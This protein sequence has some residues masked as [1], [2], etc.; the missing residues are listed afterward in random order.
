MRNHPF[1][2]RFSS[3]LDNSENLRRIVKRLP[4]HLGTKLADIAYFISEPV[5]GTDPGREPHFS[6]LAKFVDEKSRVASSMYGVDLTK[7]TIQSKHE[8]ASPS[9]NQNNTVKITTLATN[10]E[11]GVKHER[12]CSCCSGTCIALA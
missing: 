7:K 3:D 2:V 11:G 10:S 12:K 5:R 6:D 9:K 8:K 1:S 4:M